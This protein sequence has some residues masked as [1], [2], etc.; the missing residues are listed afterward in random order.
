MSQDRWAAVDTYF[1]ESLV[2]RDE[3][4]EHALETSREAG[5][6]EIQ[7]AGNQGKLLSMIARIHGAG[8]ILEVGTLG[9][10]STIWLAR[11]LPES[12]S[13]VTLE[14]DPTHAAVARQ[15]IEHAG[16]AGQVQI[17]VGRAVDSLAA[18][19]EAGEGPFDFIFIDADKPGNPHYLDYALKLSRPGTLIVVDNVVRNG[20]VADPGS[21]DPNVI[22][23]RTMIDQITA[24]QRLDATAIQTVGGKGYDGFALIHVR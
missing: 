12:G 16:Y 23:V 1:H 5:L 17:R 14:L 18:M 10:Y 20:G 2:G 13:I 15:N 7:V 19:V 24:D 9:G 6:P 4:L 3:P 22:G 8:R 11:A 21:T